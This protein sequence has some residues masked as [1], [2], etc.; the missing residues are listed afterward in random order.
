M[1]D[2]H[3]FPDLLALNRRPQALV[4]LGRGDA[5]A[6]GKRHQQSGRQVAEV[7]LDPVQVLDQVIAPGSVIPD[8]TIHRDQIGRIGPAPLDSKGLAPMRLAI[9]GS[10]LRSVNSS[11]LCG[12]VFD[13]PQR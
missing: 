13:M 10:R 12:R 2:Q 3:A 4:D 6:V 7:V 1:I 11:G 8:V 5:Q 9:Q